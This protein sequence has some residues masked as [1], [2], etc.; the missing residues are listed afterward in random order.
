MDSVDICLFSPDDST[1]VTV[2]SGNGH[3]SVW[4][5]EDWS[6]TRI[7]GRES[8]HFF[9][10]VLFSPEGSVLVTMS[11]VPFEYDTYMQVWRT[12]DWHLLNAARIGDRSKAHLFSPD[13]RFLV[14]GDGGGAARVWDI[15]TLEELD[16]L[17]GHIGSVAAC[18]FDRTNGTL[19][20]V[21]SA[22]CL[23]VW[24]D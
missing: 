22:K 1:L 19:R 20:I 8:L 3:A 9:S 17:A 15:T 14:T 11:E 12:E 23:E 21:N 24:A 5:T 16:L 18:D 6:L 10:S 2:S 4:S 7:L 13:G